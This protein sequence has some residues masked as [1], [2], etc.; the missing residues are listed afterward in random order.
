M[1]KISKVIIGICI[2]CSVILLGLYV[3]LINQKS[4]EFPP[5]PLVY[6]IFSAESSLSSYK[7]SDLFK[8]QYTLKTVP[9][10][11]DV[12][13]GDY[14]HVGNGIVFIKSQQGLVF[15]YVTE[16]EPSVSL[17]DIIMAEFPQAIIYDYTE[18]ST[19]KDVVTDDGF[20]NGYPANYFVKLLTVTN[21]T[22]TVPVYLIGYELS[23][24]GYANSVV[25]F[26]TTGINST[27]ALTEVAKMSYAQLFT[28]NYNA[29]MAE[30]LPPDKDDTTESEQVSEDAIE[31][32]APDEYIVPA[33]TVDEDNYDE[34]EYSEDISEESEGDEEE[35]TE[36]EYVEPT[37]PEDAETTS[38]DV[39]IDSDYSDGVMTVTWDNTS[40]LIECRL[41]DSSG[42]V[43]YEADGYDIGSATIPLGEVLSGDYT[44]EITGKDYGEINYSVTER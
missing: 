8:S 23:I 10:T 30:L 43:M 16:K 38:M 39:S 37:M 27:E 29:E 6:S 25:L 22:N 36:D 33:T 34:L 7:Q 32:I 24:K 35:D 5:S 15:S 40:T 31:D 28:L 21:G 41:Y 42:I 12:P 20:I 17:N 18:Q 26:N 4:V 19:I 14:A 44:L 2:F 13:R 3:F 9:Y 11:I 1:K